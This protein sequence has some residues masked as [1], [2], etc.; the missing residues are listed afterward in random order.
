VSWLKIDDRILDHPKFVRAERQ[1]ASTAIHLWVGLMSYCKQHRT[2]GWVPIDMLARVNGPRGRWRARALE[3]LIAEKLVEREGDRLHVHDYL[4]WN[5]S[6]YEIEHP[7]KGTEP[8][9]ESAPSAV[10][11]P[12][13][14]QVRSFLDPSESTVSTESASSDSKKNGHLRVARL[15]AGSESESESESESI[16]IPLG[17]PP[18]DPSPPAPAP[19]KKKSSQ[20]TGKRVCPAD[21]KPNDAVLQLATELGFST[22]LELETRATMIDW[23]I[24]KGRAHSNWQAT[25][26]NWLRREAKTRGLK[27]PVK[28]D[29]QR[30]HYQE[31]LRAAATKPSSVVPVPREYASKVRSLF[32]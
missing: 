23:S 7:S 8:R 18:V 10:L 17:I 2:D 30:E 29:P 22:A 13:E 32:S 14:I 20:P 3:A 6:R 5:P 19:V 21:F 4:D 16:R 28:H 25:Y 11:D 31:Q 12:G 1:A 9:A 26:R 24:G 15:R 27:P